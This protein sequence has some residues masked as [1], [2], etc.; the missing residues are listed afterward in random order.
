LHKSKD[1]IAIVQETCNHAVDMADEGDGVR[2][3]MLKAA[4]ELF[5]ELGY[6]A[7]T[8]KEI[9]ARANV[10]EPTLFRHFGSKVDVFEASILTPLK[11][12]IEQWSQSWVDFAENATLDDMAGN[13]VEGLYTVIRQDRRIFHELMAARSDPHS[14]LYQSAVE[15]SSQLRQ[16]LRAVHDAAFDIADRYGLPADDKP[17]TIGAVASMIIGAALFDDWAYPAN[18]RVPG[19]ERMIRELSTLIVD[20]TTHREE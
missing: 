3:R 20:G 16:G 12:Y 18:I 10:A 17:A 6:R 15:V 14:D 7:T 9:A 11:T 8:T 1:S 4:H 19:R 2:A 13:L 5:T